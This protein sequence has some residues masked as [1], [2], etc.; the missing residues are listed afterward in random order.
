MRTGQRP[1]AL[2]DPLQPVLNHG[3]DSC[4]E[5]G[6]VLIMRGARGCVT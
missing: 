3:F 2:F 1:R 4:Q 5:P 6:G